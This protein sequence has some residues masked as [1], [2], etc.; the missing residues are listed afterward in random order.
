MS[1]TVARENLKWSIR[2]C[3]TVPPAAT[4][5]LPVGHPGIF[6]VREKMLMFFHLTRTNTNPPPNTE[7]LSVVVPIVY[8]IEQNQTSIPQKDS[9]N[10][11]NPV[12]MSAHNILVSLTNSGALNTQRCTIMPCVREI[13][14]NLALPNEGPTIMQPGHGGPGGMNR[15][16]M[17]G[18]PHPMGGPQGGAPPMRMMNPGMMPQQRMMMQPQQHGYMG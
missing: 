6:R 1:E 3:L 5:L 12:M 9:I 11:N 18:P 17:G 8:D 13:L 2:L 10:L 7:P 15:P 16:P 4:G 14:L